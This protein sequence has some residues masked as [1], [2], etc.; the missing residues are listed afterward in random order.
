LE[1]PKY[2]AA[3]EEVVEK[4]KEEKEYKGGLGISFLAILFII[5][6]IL[7]NQK[8]DLLLY[9]T[10]T[11]YSTTDNFTAHFTGGHKTLSGD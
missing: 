5:Y 6:L 9:N 7:P 1:P 10:H 4:G 11:S 8:C 2:E 3:K